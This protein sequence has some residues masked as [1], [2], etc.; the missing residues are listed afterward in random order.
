MYVY[1]YAGYGLNK[2]AHIASLNYYNFSF[3]VQPG[4]WLV[5]RPH[6]DTAVRNVVLPLCI[7]IHTVIY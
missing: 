1:V 3:V 2:I 4:A 6:E 7:S 5:H